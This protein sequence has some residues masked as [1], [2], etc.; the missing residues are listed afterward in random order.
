MQQLMS[1][2]RD[3][4]NSVISNPGTRICFRLGDFDAKKL[5]EGFSYFDFRDLLNLGIGEAIVRIERADHDFNIKTMVSPQIDPEVTRR[6]RERVV[7]LSRKKYAYHLEEPESQLVKEEPQESAVAVFSDLKSMTGEVEKEKIESRQPTPSEKP[8]RKTALV[9][10]ELQPEEKSFLKFISQHPDM[11]VTKVYKALRLSGYKGDKIKTSLIEKGLIVQ[12][13]TRKGLLR[14]LAKVLRLTDKGASIVEK[15]LT[16]GKGGDLHKD[17][18]HMVKEQ[19]ELFGWRAKLEERIPRSLESVDVGLDKDGIRV[20]VEISS[21]TP[22]EHEVQN[23]RKCL[24]AGYDYILAVCDE[25]KR[26]SQIKTEVKKAFSFK[27]RERIRFYHTSR[28]KEFLSSVG[29]KDIV[30]EKGI[31]SDQIRK[32]KQLMDSTETAEFLGISK[33]TLYEWTSQKRVP[34][35]KVGGLLKFKRA[36]LE[37]WLKKR[38]QEEGNFDIL[39]EE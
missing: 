9:K 10:A 34:Y 12:E 39:D 38:T 27:E 15:L 36:D 37:E 30:S 11:F 3:L 14:R 4:A 21:T 5:E 13:E 17:L 32:Q 26:L 7:E 19:A 35:I 2:N 20:A 18:Q 22:P 23:I 31:V 8:A 33:N 28:V 6:C 29:P 25:D 24:D 1:R 16:A